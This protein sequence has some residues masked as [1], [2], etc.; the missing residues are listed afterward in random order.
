MITLEPVL[1]T[2]SCPTLWD[3]MDC[4]PPGSS[5][6]GILQARI[7]EWVA[8]PF[9]RGSSWPKDQTWVSVHC[10]WVLYCLSHQRR[11]GGLQGRHWAHPDNPEQPLYL[12]GL[13]LITS[14]KP[15]FQHKVT[16]P[17]VPGNKIWMS[18]RASVNVITTVRTVDIIGFSALLQKVTSLFLFYSLYK[19]DRMQTFTITPLEICPQGKEN[20]SFGC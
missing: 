8:I 13:N 5:V 1:V 2:Q 20:W 10:R 7:L 3:P 18:S 12:K 17:Q 6:H 11:P 15:F 14:T 19:K 9:S 4:S 16:Y